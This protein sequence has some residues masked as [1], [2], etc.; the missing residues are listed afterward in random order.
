[1]PEPSITIICRRCDRPFQRPPTRG[2]KPAKCPA[3]KTVCDVATC[4]RPA[5]TRG[6]CNGHYDRWRRYGDVRASTPFRERL[7]DRCSIPGCGN[8]PR[9]MR[10][11]PLCGKHLWRVRVH[12]NTEL[13]VRPIKCLDCDEMVMPV[14]LKANRLKRCGACSRKHRVNV[15]REARASTPRVCTDCGEQYPKTVE[16]RPGSTRRCPACL[17]AREAEKAARKRAIC[18][19]CGDVFG[20]ERSFHLVA[21]CS[22]ACRQAGKET[23]RLAMKALCGPCEVDGCDKKKR[24]PG[25][26]HCEKHYIRKWRHGSEDIVYGRKPDRKCFHCEAPVARRVKFCSTVCTRRF[27][28]RVPG[29]DMSCVC[30][31]AALPELAMFTTL[32]CSNECTRTAERAKKYGVTPAEMYAFTRAT[33]CQS[34]G[35]ADADLVVDH[36]HSTGRLRGMLCGQCNV[37]IGMFADDAEKLK[38]A[39]AYLRRHALNNVAGEQLMLIG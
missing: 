11:D 16:R 13:E 35:R 34:C 18:K 28:L 23:Q 5:E 3:C 31:S 20:D 14:S 21:Y 19:N 15:D 25:A 24:S 4:T 32:Y 10:P 39:I 7:P 8:R 26:K 38:K 36:C 1:M 17:D 9:G 30:C 29:R 33:A 2:P 22:P 12:G 6:W 37:G 27:A